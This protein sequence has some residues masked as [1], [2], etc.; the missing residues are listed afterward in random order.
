M[1]PMAVPKASTKVAAEALDLPHLGTVEPGKVAD[2]IVA[3]ENPLENLGALRNLDLI[4]KAGKLLTPK[5]FI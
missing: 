2:L 3:R 1:S 4:V 5:I